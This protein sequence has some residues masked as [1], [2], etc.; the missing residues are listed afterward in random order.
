MFG[1]WRSS[2]SPTM[3]VIFSFKYNTH[4]QH[5]MQDKTPTPFVFYVSLEA[6]QHAM[7]SHS[8]V[9]Q[10]LSRQTA[11]LSVC[12][13]HQ[14]ILATYIQSGRSGV[15]QIMPIEWRNTTWCSW[16]VLLPTDDTNSIT[17]YQHEPWFSQ[18][19]N[20]DTEPHSRANMGAAGFTIGHYV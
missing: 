6:S 9:L 1:K 4:W 10:Q 5:M 3:E 12:L 18:G 20:N 7:M 13:L 19:K 15:C 14:N 16:C 11:L 8:P 2:V 17:A